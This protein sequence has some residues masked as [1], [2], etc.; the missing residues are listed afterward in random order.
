MFCPPV[1]DIPDAL[2]LHRW[3]MT[4][5]LESLWRA[6]CLANTMTSRDAQS[7][8]YFV[9]YKLM[10]IFPHSLISPSF[11]ERIVEFKH[12][13]LPH[14]CEHFPNFLLGGIKT[15]DWR[16]PSARGDSW[17]WKTQCFKEIILLHF[18]ALVIN[19]SRALILAM[20]EWQWAGL[21]S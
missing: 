10:G 3:G 17:S 1:F 2:S 20:W 21:A 14:G 16:F 4:W 15:K 6:L 13:E 7:G 9:I 5:N 8:L 19:S 18:V 11:A 12:P